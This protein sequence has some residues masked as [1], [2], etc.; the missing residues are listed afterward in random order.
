[1]HN[2]RRKNGMTMVELIFAVGM[3]MLLSVS[4]YQIMRAVRTTFTH[5]Q[6]KLD[7]LQTTRIIMSGIR[8]ELRNASDKPQV[9]NDRLNIPVSPTETVQYYF[10]P[11]TRRLY[12]GKKAGINDPDPGVSDMRPFMFNDG[13]ILSFE[14]DSSYR[15]SNAFV[16]SELALNSKVWFK[17]SMKILYSE[18]FD[19]LTEADKQKILDKP[20]DDPRVKSFFMVI[21]PRKVNWLLQATQ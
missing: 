11:E 17:V 5:S 10:N 6:N 1:M 14:Y 2:N 8:N 15:D 4:M 18:K 9:F 16:E 12:R 20:D 7:I 13:Q 3:F 21:T 19:K